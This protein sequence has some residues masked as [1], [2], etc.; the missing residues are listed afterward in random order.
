M[1]HDDLGYL[2]TVFRK[3]IRSE[4]RTAAI[5]YVPAATPL[6]VDHEA[7]DGLVAAA[8]EGHMADGV[9]PRWFSRP[10]LGLIW[11]ALIE[12]KR[13]GIEPTTERVVNLLA[14]DG[15]A[16]SGVSAEVERLFDWTGFCRPEQLAVRLRNAH[17]RRQVC[18]LA[19]QIDA[20]A[21]T[22]G[23]VSRLI[24]QLTAVA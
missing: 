10:L 8:R 17:R 11:I 23:D 22:G 14:R 9:D 2:E 19:M 4:I 21:R 6:P 13:A 24:E 1:N 20:L 3:T 5:L 16:G 7:E 12:C 18:D 15:W